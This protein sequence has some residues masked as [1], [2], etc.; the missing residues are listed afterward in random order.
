MDGL[1]LG[2]ETTLQINA[3]LRMPAM[4]V[5]SAAGLLSLLSEPCQNDDL[6]RHALVNIEKVVDE[7]WFQI[8]GSIASIEALYEDDEFSHRE[9]AALVASKVRHVAAMACMA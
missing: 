3:I 6:K 9:M 7:H 5:S 8:S 2:N 1:E 4:V